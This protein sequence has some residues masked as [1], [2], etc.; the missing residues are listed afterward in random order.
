MPGWP[1]SLVGFLATFDLDA[2]REAGDF[3]PFYLHT[4]LG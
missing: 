4:K 3:D 1:A 2:L